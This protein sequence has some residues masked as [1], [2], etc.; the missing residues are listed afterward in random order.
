MRRQLAVAVA[1][2]AR[3]GGGRQG[4]APT[5]EV[6][7]HAPLPEKA[8]ATP[9]D[10]TG[11][12]DMVCALMCPIPRRSWRQPGMPWI[13]GFDEISCLGL[14]TGNQVDGRFWVQE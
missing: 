5:A 6:E 14:M 1:V 8:P 7:A 2:V 4:E 13:A 10:Q 3:G 9:G 12:M 11:V